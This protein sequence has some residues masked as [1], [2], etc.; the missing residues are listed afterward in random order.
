MPPR[1][2]PSFEPRLRS[3]RLVAFVVL[4]ATIAA[5]SP[6]VVA[7]QAPATKP[8]PIGRPAP[9][10]ALTQGPLA[11]RL[12]AIDT[13]ARRGTARDASRLMPLLHDP[14]PQI[15]ARAEPAIW[16]LWGR[17]G[18]AATD[19][20]YRK[21]VDLLE[22]GDLDAAID[23]F[24]AIIARRPAFAEAWNKRATALFLAGR[25]DESLA[26]CDEVL[27]RVPDH[28]GVLAGYGQIWL[29][30]D[31]PDRVVE[32]WERALAVNPN[33]QSIAQAIEVVRRESTQRGRGRT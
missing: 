15:R 5:A 17:S 20:G 26:D 14:E 1:P 28:F 22:S 8:A 2:L 7:A 24:G 12:A 13:L 11:T 33:L 30:K 25:L 27:R 23:A 4:I 9:D 29:R 6:G 32:F 19:A 21:G 16:S 18:D 31:E 10:T 3:S